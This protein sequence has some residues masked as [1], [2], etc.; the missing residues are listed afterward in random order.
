M[1]IR[2]EDEVDVSPQPALEFL[3]EQFHHLKAV[4]SIWQQLND[5]VYVTVWS[6]V[7]SDRRAEDSQAVHTVAVLQGLNRSCRG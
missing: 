4:I 2:L 7:A 3:L 6:E 1:K 5:D